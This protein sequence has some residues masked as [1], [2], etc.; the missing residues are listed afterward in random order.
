MHWCPL[1]LAQLYEYTYTAHT[2]YTASL[3][4]ALNCCEW[5]VV[6]GL[7]FGHT[8]GPNGTTKLM[9]NGPGRLEDESVDSFFRVIDNQ[10]SALSTA[11]TTAGSQASSVRFRYPLGPR[12]AG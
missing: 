3:L 7:P 9:Y 4:L 1:K 5:T 2:Y 6:N 12:R 11:P 8:L 10:L